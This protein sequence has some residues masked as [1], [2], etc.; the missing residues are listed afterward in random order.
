MVAFGI[1]G[2]D[3]ETV[4]HLHRGAVL[5]KVRVARTHERD[6]DTRLRRLAPRVPSCVA[7]RPWGE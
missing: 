2:G 5:G 7:V 1:E 3:H 4:N 6:P